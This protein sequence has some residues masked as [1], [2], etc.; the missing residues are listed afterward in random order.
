MQMVIGQRGN[1]PIGRL[2]V[3]KSLQ[4]NV[5]GFCVIETLE[6][7]RPHVLAGN[8]RSEILFII[9]RIRKGG[10]KCLDI[11]FVPK[12]RV[13]HHHQ[14]AGVQSTA[15][16]DA[17]RNVASQAQANRLFQQFE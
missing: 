16:I 6:L 14:A 9:P 5:P 7:A 10:G 8:L 2:L 4:S 3:P 1:A 13:H 12:Q 15:E 17:K 11:A